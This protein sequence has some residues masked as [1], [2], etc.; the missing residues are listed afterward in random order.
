METVNLSYEELLKKVEEQEKEIQI[1]KA[2]QNGGRKELFQTLFTDSYSIKLIIDFETGQIIN[3]NKSACKF[4]GY[5]YDEITSMNINQIN[6]LSPEEIKKEMQ[7]AKSEVR[8]YFNFKHRLKNRQIKDVEVHSG[9]IL[10]ENKIFL[11]SI[12]HDVTENKRKENELE[13]AKLELIENEQLYRETFEHAA[14][15]I[16]HVEPSG[17]FLK[18]NQKFC[19]IVGYSQKELKN[20]NFADITHQDDLDIDKKQIEKVIAN[21]INSFT[22]TKRYIHKNGENIWI[23]LYSN[24]IRGKNNQI[25]FAIASILDVTRQ[26]KLRDELIKAKE[27]AEESDRLKSAF[28]QNLSHEIRTP[29]NAI[30]GFSG[31]LNKPNLSEEKRNSFVSIIQNS[32][33]QLLSIISHVLTISALETN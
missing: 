10:I 17:R 32:S 11:Y 5:S 19:D 20:L 28:L 18:V 6:T 12:I 13:I 2:N 27:K 8:N 3:A 4:Y 26:K 16:A 15:G 7:N 23:S 21:K 9:K 29:L 31:R 33:N 1:L 24:V 25:K 14:I 30:C 22:I